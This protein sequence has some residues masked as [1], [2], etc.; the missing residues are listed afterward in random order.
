MDIKELL[1]LFGILISNAAIT[2]T[3]CNGLLKARD[4]KLDNQIDI[5]RRELEELKQLAD[6]NR[7]RLR[8]AASV[9]DDFSSDVACLV[10]YYNG[11]IGMLSTNTAGIV[12]TAT[13]IWFIN[14]VFPALAGSL[15]MLGIKIFKRQE[16][17]TIKH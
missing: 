10:E 3:I 15:F 7:D 4:N 9:F 8:I 2:V 14:R 6:R 11:L 5:F 17:G 13:A 12:F 16:T 1:P